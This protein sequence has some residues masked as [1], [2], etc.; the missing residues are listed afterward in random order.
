MAERRHSEPDASRMTFRA[1]LRDATEYQKAEA[2][3]GLKIA[4]ALETS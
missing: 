1:T 2:S 3:R 4:D